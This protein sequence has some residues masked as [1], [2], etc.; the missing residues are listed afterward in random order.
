MN[1]ETIK[2]HKKHFFF[3]MDGT[4]TESRQ[5][6]TDEVRDCFD[7]L[8]KAGRDIIVISG[9]A[10][11]QM[12]QQ[13]DSSGVDYLL[14][15]SGNDSDFWQ[16][17]FTPLDK[18]EVLK[19]VE[20]IEDFFEGKNILGE[21][22]DLLQDRGSQMS[23][24]FLGHNFDVVKKR[25][26]DP[27]GNFRKEVLSAVPFISNNL[28]CRVAGTT[29]FDYTHKGY[30]KGKNIENL[31]EHLNWQ[32]DECVYFGDALFEGGNDETVIGIIDTIEVSDPKEL[33]RKLREIV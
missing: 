22:V 1:I 24:S 9:A 7:S 18:L 27:G 31:I 4:V 16:K 23:F 26:F 29:C 3:D 21:K 30:A 20:Q 13:L 19:H 12:N 14:A 17:F 2:K 25:A 32:K 8:K 15:Q 33:A 28:E 5:K 10:R 6:I 11:D